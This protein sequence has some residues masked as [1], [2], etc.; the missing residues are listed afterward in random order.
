MRGEKIKILFFILIPVLLF[1]AC[2]PGDRKVDPSFYYWKTRFKLEDGERAYLDALKA[3]TLYI[4]FF[5]VDWNI[6]KNEPVPIASVV[7]DTTGIK[8][9]KII[10]TIYITNRAMSSI[11]F[12]DVPALGDKI[13]HRIDRIAGPVP[14]HEIQ[15]DCDWTEKSRDNYFRL[16]DHLRTKLVA[17]HIQLSATI[18]LHQIKYYNLTGVPPVD[19]GMLMFYNMGDIRDISEENTILDLETAE[20]YL[21]NFDEYPTHLDIALPVFAWGVVIRNDETIHLINNLRAEQLKDESK[22]KFL[23]P[24]IV[25]V[26]KNTYI[27]GYY[28]YQDDFIR[29][30]DISIEALEESAEML[31]ELI[32]SDSVRVCFYHLDTPTLERYSY[33]D[34]NGICKVF[35]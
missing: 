22:F 16:L 28:L 33:E 7:F 4:R 1:P 32:E 25:K 11:G 21:E 35:Y 20:K 30:E 5:D 14:F 26:V 27:N 17:R 6:A 8:G 2:G 19:R 13:L 23:Q 3:E 18:R 15:M 9:K 10:P 34:L 29:L 31:A 12:E 24:S